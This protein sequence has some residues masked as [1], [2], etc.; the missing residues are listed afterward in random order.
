MV[1]IGLPL[2]VRVKYGYSGPKGMTYFEARKAAA[3]LG[4]R[5]ASHVVADDHV[6]G[7]YPRGSRYRAGISREILVLPQNERFKETDV[8]D[9]QSGLVFPS[10]Y[11]PPEF[12]NIQNAG[13]LVDHADFETTQKGMAVV[14]NGNPQ[15]I[16]NL[17]S[18]EHWG[19]NLFFYPM[20]PATRFPST[21]MGAATDI[22]DSR[23]TIDFREG[24]HRYMGFACKPT[25][26]PIHRHTSDDGSFDYRQHHAGGIFVISPLKT[27]TA[28][29]VEVD[30][31]EARAM[32]EKIRKMNKQ[33]EEH[34]GA[35]FRVL[36]RGIRNFLK[37]PYP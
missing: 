2:I 21:T 32:A 34:D 37:R 24:R 31:D 1:A 8:V 17:P 35:W 30:E 7:K 28:H 13:L 3:G 23:K 4:C 10:V 11:I 12:L 33:Q 20:D 36:G 27:S 5:L 26:A 22:T 19:S 9:A 16:L 6:V 25:V 15:I 18:A 14:P 29:L